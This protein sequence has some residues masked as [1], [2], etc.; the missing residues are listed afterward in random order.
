MQGVSVIIPV[1]LGRAAQ[2]E[3]KKKPIHSFGKSP[4]EVQF[5]CHAIYQKH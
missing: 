3:E 5:C 2:Q 4:L 1:V